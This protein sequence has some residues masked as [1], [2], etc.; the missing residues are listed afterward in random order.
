LS[1]Y[2]G[3]NWAG[4]RLQLNNQDDVR[5]SV[6]PIVGRATD[7]LQAPS[8]N[9]STDYDNTLNV[10]I[11]SGDPADVV[12]ATHA[13]VMADANMAFLGRP[14][15]W[16]IIQ[17]E[18]VVEEANGTLTLGILQRGR[19]GSEVWQGSHAYN[20]YFIPI[21]RASLL[22][23]YSETS[24]L[25]G[26]MGYRYGGVGL[27]NSQLTPA[28]STVT[29]TATSIHNMKLGAG[30]SACKATA[31]VDAAGCTDPNAGS[32]L[33]FWKFQRPLSDTV[34]SGE[35]DRLPLVF[36]C[37]ALSRP[38]PIIAGGASAGSALCVYAASQAGT[39]FITAMWV[40][41]PSENF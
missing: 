40:E 37:S 33:E 26:L 32:Y 30:A 4:G 18:T 34:A 1:G 2:T 41:E 19:L 20:D 25:S 12:S 14:G 6:T 36:T 17:W 23:F 22:V 29:G 3:E 8:A 9:W 16:E 21:D 7:I 27:P 31:A 39:G 11:I 38:A 5:S 24:K 15:R 28:S 35:N 13:E 10:Q